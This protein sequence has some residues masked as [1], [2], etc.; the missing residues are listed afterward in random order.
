[1]T[2]TSSLLLNTKSVSKKLTGTK[3]EPEPALPV[4]FWPRPVSTSTHSLTRRSHKL[5]HQINVQKTDSVEELQTHTAHSLTCICSSQLIDQELIICVNY[6]IKT[7]RIK[8][9]SFSL[10]LS[11]FLTV[12]RKWKPFSASCQGNM[13]VSGSMTS[14]CCSWLIYGW[15][16]GCS[17]TTDQWDPIKH[18]W[19]L[20]K[21]RM[22]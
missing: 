4:E 3:S 6:T 21:R 5:H 10:L 20:Q 11:L 8:H 1:M 2:H 15:I 14:S 18:S 12:T 22:C 17:S 13:E 9:S 16:N 7:N 19:F